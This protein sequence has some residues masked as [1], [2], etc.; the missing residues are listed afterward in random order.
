MT[1]ALAV[2]AGG[3]VSPL[4]PA[5]PPAAPVAGVKGLDNYPSLEHRL[6]LRKGP[7]FPMQEVAAPSRPAGRNVV[8]V[9]HSDVGGSRRPQ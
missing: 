6:K 1:G 5:S 9:P 8:S 2:S 3:S 4:A 7:K